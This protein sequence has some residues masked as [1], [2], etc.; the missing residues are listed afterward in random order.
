MFAVFL[1]RRD[2]ALRPPANSRR[3]A[4]EPAFVVDED[5]ARRRARSPLPQ[6]EIGVRRARA[7]GERADLH[8]DMAR[9]GEAVGQTLRS[10]NDAGQH[11]RFPGGA[12]QISL[13]HAQRAAALI[14]RGVEHGFGIDFVGA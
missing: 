14:L 10:G 3:T 12:S 9:R 13:C 8:S 5:N 2:S 4:G 11:F 1:Q 6:Y 7:G